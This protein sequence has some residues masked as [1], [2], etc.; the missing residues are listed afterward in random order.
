MESHTL[1]HIVNPVYVPP[2]SRFY[3][4][5]KVTYES[6]RV[7]REYALPALEVDL[8]SA[9]Y[10]EDHSVLP[11]GFHQTPDL[12]RSVLD[13]GKFSPPR[14]LPLLSDIIQRLYTASE[15]E[16]FIYTNVDI[17][18]QPH[19]YQTVSR[20]LIEGHRA[21]TINRRIISEDYDKLDQLP[22]M[23]ADSGE[24]HRGWD[25]FVF[26]RENVPLFHLG[27]VCLGAPLVGLVL[28]TNLIAFHDTFRQFPDEHLTF[29]IGDDRAWHGWRNPY[30]AHNRREALNLLTDLDR[31]IG[32]FPRHSPPGSFLANHRHPFRAMLYDASRQVHIPLR[33]IQPMKRA[34]RR[35][36]PWSGL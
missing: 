31:L 32:G 35:L 2:T 19:F 3:F 21:F 23:H 13:L 20:F 9:Q 34:L 4:I 22:L 36:I 12:D 25:C 28:L 14:K 5:Q 8:F 33:F 15:A 7:A 17:G 29:H 27:K 6:M 30:A 11:A 24:P 16:Y 26:P 18:L 10:P 1:A